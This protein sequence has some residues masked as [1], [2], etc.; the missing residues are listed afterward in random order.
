LQLNPKQEEAK[1]K[2]DGPLL[3]IAGAG[4]GKTATLTQ[5]VNYMISE[6]GI[7]PSNVL[8]VTFTNKAAREMR[9]RVAARL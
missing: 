8:M 3:I 4:S 9:E 6:K 7:S 2:I 5:R 1:N